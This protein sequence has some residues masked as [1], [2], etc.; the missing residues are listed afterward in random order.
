MFHLARLE[1][2]VV[3]ILPMS[4]Q[5]LIKLGVVDMRIS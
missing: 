4:V 3:R 5:V 2:V 1:V